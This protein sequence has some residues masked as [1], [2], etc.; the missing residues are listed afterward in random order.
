MTSAFAV[1]LAVALQHGNI[2]VLVAGAL[3]IAASAKFPILSLVIYWPGLTVAGA[4]AGGLVGLVSALALLIPGPTVCVR[5]L[6]F[7]TPVFPSE[8]P[9]L[10]T[11]PIAFLVAWGVSTLTRSTEARDR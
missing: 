1:A 2:A 9:T 7:P 8:Y 5:L 3:V 10:V 6:G 11:M 4:M